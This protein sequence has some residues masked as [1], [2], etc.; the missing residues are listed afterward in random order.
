[1][2]ARDIEKRLSEGA[3]GS[4]RKPLL[5]R[6]ARQV[7]KTFAVRLYAGA[8]DRRSVRTPSGTPY[9]LLSLPYYL[10]AKLPALAP[11]DV[12]V[13]PG[14]AAGMPGLAELRRAATK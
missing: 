9:E 8:L 2:F 14:E 10:A 4:T 12:V 6:G 11:A 7:G 3:E 1:M 5:L 13:G